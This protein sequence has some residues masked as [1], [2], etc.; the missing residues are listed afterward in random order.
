MTYVHG[1]VCMHAHTMHTRTHDTY[2]D[3]AYTCTYPYTSYIS[4]VGM[5]PVYNYLLWILI[6]FEIL[7]QYLK[8]LCM[9]I[10]VR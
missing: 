2:T 10:T 5:T 3:I 9:I 8:Y 1:Y 6:Y 7:L 4:F